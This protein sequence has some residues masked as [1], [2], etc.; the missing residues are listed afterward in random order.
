VFER[1]I[2]GTFLWFALMRV[3]IGLQLIF[4]FDRI[5]YQLPLGA[6]RQFAD[7]AIRRAGSAADE[8]YDSEFAI[9]HRAIMAGGQRRVKCLSEL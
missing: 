3:E 2:D 9:R 1:V 8:S 6:E 5:G 7:I 4:G